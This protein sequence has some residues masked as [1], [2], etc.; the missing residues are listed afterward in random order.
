MNPSKYS[1]LLFLAL[2]VLFEGGCA[3]A[4]NNQSH[5]PFNNTVPPAAQSPSAPSGSGPVV[6][7]QPPEPLPKPIINTTIAPAPTPTPPPLP[8]G[9]SNTKI[10]YPDS[11][12]Q[13]PNGSITQ[14]A[15]S[16]GTPQASQTLPEKEKIQTAVYDGPDSR[17]SS[18]KPVS[19]D[20]PKK[21]ERNILP[22]LPKKQENKDLKENK[23]NSDFGSYADN[24]KPVSKPA[25]VNTGQEREK[26]ETN[27][28]SVG[29]KREKPEEI[30]G[31]PL[32]TPSVKGDNKSKEGT[33]DAAKSPDPS[34]QTFSA[35]VHPNSLEPVR[36]MMIPVSSQ[37][38]QAL[39]AEPAKLREVHFRT[40]VE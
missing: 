22:I 5:N 9:G 25:F 18:V 32:P 36:P 31:N 38:S 30:S 24:H 1:A 2:S 15:D 4:P 12:G 33:P 11:S 28:S 40:I 13:I 29:S 21:D 16:Q 7:P 6:P 20:L 34:H 37:S 26:K 39:L 10:V 17:E 19:A 27:S 14:K 8:P 23:D 35:P 3:T